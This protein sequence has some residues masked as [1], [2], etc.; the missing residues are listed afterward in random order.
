MRRIAPTLLLLLTAVPP[1]GAQSTEPRSVT[2]LRTNGTPSLNAVAEIVRA[3]PEGVLLLDMKS[4]RAA[5]ER[6]L[7]AWRPTQI[8]T[9]DDTQKAEP[10]GQDS[11]E[12]PTTTCERQCVAVG[13]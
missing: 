10:V 2:L 11:I 1:L 6:F 8:R 4:I 13:D 3:D 7:E 12:A 5:N 9:I